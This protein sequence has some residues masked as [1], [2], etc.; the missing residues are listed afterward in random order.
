MAP[1][2]TTIAPRSL[3]C[4][5]RAH[6]RLAGLPNDGEDE[7]QLDTCHFFR[8]ETQNRALPHYGLEAVCEV[9]ISELVPVQRSLDRDQLIHA[10]D[11][12]E[13]HEVSGIRTDTGHISVQ[14]G[15]HGVA[16]AVLAG[17]TTL[18]VRVRKQMTDEF[19]RD[20]DGRWA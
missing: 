15:H 4:K 8:H 13:T 12:P 3:D 17:E 16:A 18:L 6:L 9:P 20:A 7:E 1:H 14:D 10:I 5:R 2:P 19:V 11:C